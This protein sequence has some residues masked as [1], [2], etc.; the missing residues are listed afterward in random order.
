[1]SDEKRVRL[2]WTGRDLLFEGGTGPGATV[3]LD[4]AGKLAPSPMDALMLALAGCMAIDVK[5]ILDKG[6]VP[7]RTLAV[8]VFGLRR[9][10]MP[11]RFTSLRLVY[12]VE[13]PQEEDAAKLERAVALSRDKYCSVLH[14]LRPDIDLEIEIRRT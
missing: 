5:M 4:S 12:E 13:G 3:A 14:S 7:V 9:T 10:E 8:E 11:R 6:R 2:A 1:M